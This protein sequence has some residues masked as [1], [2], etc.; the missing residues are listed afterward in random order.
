MRL[1]NRFPIWKI[2]TTSSLLL[3]L[4]CSTACTKTLPI[5]TGCPPIPAAI[6]S[7]EPPEIGPLADGAANSDA[8]RFLMAYE[9]WSLRGWAKLEQARRVNEACGR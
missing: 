5:R 2:L 1:F 8:I 3:S 9:A 4:A 6:L 7:Y